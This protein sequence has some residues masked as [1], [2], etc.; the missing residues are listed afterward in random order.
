MN[1]FCLMLLYIGLMLGLAGCQTAIE[2]VVIT[3]VE[4]RVVAIT[5]ELLEPCVTTYPPAKQ[6]YIQAKLSGRIEILETYVNQLLYDIKLCNLDKESIRKEQDAFLK[7]NQ[8][9]K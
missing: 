1:K 5:P 9:G 8:E 3:K 2:P 6:A 4:H 7:I